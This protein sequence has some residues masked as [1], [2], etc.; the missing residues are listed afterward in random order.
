M[1]IGLKI[2]PKVIKQQAVKSSNWRYMS[3]NEILNEVLLAILIMLCVA[4]PFV[5][6][7]NI[8]VDWTS[9]TKTSLHS[10]FMLSQI[11]GWAVGDDGVIIHWNG[12]DWSNVTSPVTNRLNSVSMISADDGWA[13]GYDGTI[14]HWNGTSWSNMTF[15]G[16]PLAS[17]SMIN[18]NDGWAVGGG[19]ILRWSGV[20]WNAVGGPSDMKSLW[21]VSMAS[22]DNA[23][24]VGEGGTI[25]YWDGTKWSKVAS[26]TENDLMSVCMVNATDGWAV[27]KDSMI[28]WN[29]GFW[30]NATIPTNLD[31]TSVYMI[32]SNDGWAVSKSWT[33]LHWDGTKWNMVIGPTIYYNLWSV[34]MIDSNDGWAVGENGTM[35]RWNG[36]QWIPENLSLLMPPSLMVGTLLAVTV[37][38]RKKS[39]LRAALTPRN[40]FDDTTA[41][42]CDIEQF[43][44][45]AVGNGSV[46]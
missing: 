32:N 42:N 34:F 5:N 2:V 36:T 35:V 16:V 43:S 29:G 1:I 17:L 40:S 31:L 13:V 18:T 37:Y 39:A 4:I 26:P 8:P 24:A 7:E 25:I 9:P 38:Q 21:S 12:T 46:N 28:H 41:T 3:T 23:W 45:R 19:T 15:P 30:D 27:G 6:A 22:T 44:A 11:D 33:T 14:L 20:T 10:I